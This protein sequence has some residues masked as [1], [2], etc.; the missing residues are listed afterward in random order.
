MLDSMLALVK[1]NTGRQAK[2]ISADAG[3]CSESNLRKLN[4]RHVRGY[5]A[6]GRQQHGESA[7][8]SRLGQKPGT[9]TYEMRV[10]IAKGGFRSRYRL[11]KQ[12]VEP[13]IGQIKSALG[14]TGFLLRGLEKVRHGWALVCMAS[15]LRKLATASG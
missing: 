8:R 12:V 6:T 9:A 4:R 10:R 11:R 7:P 14:F 1:K 13:V 5:V 15:N 3:Y 2:E